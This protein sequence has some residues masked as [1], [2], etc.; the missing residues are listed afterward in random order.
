MM[1]L[2]LAKADNMHYQRVMIGLMPRSSQRSFLRLKDYIIRAIPVSA[3][4][5]LSHVVLTS[6]SI[7]NAP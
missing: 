6:P 4:S 5:A 7:G 2:K 1:I 3:T